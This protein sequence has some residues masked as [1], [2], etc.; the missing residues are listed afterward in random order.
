MTDQWRLEQDVDLNDVYPY[1]VTCNLGRVPPCTL[2]RSNATTSTCLAAA[3]RQAEATAPA[4][5][6]S[7]TVFVTKDL[8]L[9]Q[10]IHNVAC[11]GR[12]SSCRVRAGDGP[13]TQP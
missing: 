5:G 4:P 12:A 10:K 1:G 2:R 7:A 6:A 11:D 8:L 3:T 9:E 13:S